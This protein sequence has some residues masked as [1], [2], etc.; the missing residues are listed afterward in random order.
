M[1]SGWPKRKRWRGA[2]SA[3]KRNLP[4][5]ELT[6]IIEF[7]VIPHHLSKEFL[8]RKYT[9]EK[10]SIAQIAAQISS[11]KDIVRR[12][13]IRFGIVIRRPIRTM[14]I[15]HRLVMAKDDPKW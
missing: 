10:L 7:P 6:N 1:Q 5:L 11:S 9:V 3:R 4:P 15:R 13:L 12:R 8:H 2:Q 14:A